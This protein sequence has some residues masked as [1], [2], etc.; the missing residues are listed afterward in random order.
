MRRAGLRVGQF[1]SAGVRPSG[2]LS[3]HAHWRAGTR[4]L[5]ARAVVAG[6]WGSGCDAVA[7]FVATA[8]AQVQSRLW[9]SLVI[10]S[11]V[12][13]GD[14][15]AGHEPGLSADAGSAIPAVSLAM[16]AGGQPRLCGVRD[17]R[18]AAFRGEVRRCIALLLV[19]LIAVCNRALQ[20]RLRSR[21]HAVHDLQRVSYR[22]WLHGD[23]RVR[24]RRRRQLRDQAGL[25]R[26]SIAQ[27][28]WQCAADGRTRDAISRQPFIASSSRSSRR[29]RLPSCLRLMNY[30]AWRVE[31]NGATVTPQSDD[32]TGRMVIAL[33]AGRSE[34]DVRFVR[35]PD[36]WIGRRCEFRLR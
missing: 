34:V 23:R 15:V 28:G 29:S 14:D 33:P 6:D 20:P 21:R 1:L 2:E 17:Y 13:A 24:S 19:G 18:G 4:Q 5:S 31:V 8:M 10:L 3:F 25:S 27:R 7:V 36:R 35:T 12:V 26:L 32:P 9:W 22:I 16:V 30:P 11:G